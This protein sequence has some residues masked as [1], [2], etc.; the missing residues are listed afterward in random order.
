MLE[1]KE[2]S[3]KEQIF[4]TARSLFA[5]NGYK[6]TSQRDL[7]AE[8]GIEAPSLYSYISGK[9]EL[10]QNIILPIA[11]QFIEALESVQTLSE[12]AGTRM[13]KLIRAHIAI[14]I[15][16]LEASAVF[17]NEHKNLTA[18]AKERFYEMRTRY[19][20][21][22]TEILSEGVTSCEFEVEDVKI[23]SMTMLTALNNIW[24]WYDAGYTTGDDLANQIINSFLNGIKAQNQ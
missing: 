6:A 4:N 16:D 23:A 18:E 20:N 11:E 19:E 15:R 17:W 1:V 9:E 8:L 10:L 12:S 3:R 7:A 22:F 5:R 2:P 21:A 24:H 14:V 13:E